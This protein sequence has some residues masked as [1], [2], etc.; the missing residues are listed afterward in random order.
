M[1]IKK[2]QIMKYLFQ[3]FFGLMAL[4][5]VSA[6]S[7]FSFQSYENDPT[8]LRLYTLDNGL[9]VYLA[10]NSDEPKIQTYIAVRAGSNYDPAD[11]TGLAHYLEHMLFKGT[12]KIGT[13]NWEIEKPYLDKISH[14]YEKHKAEPNEEKKKS[15]YKQIDSISYE[16]SKKCIANDYDKMLSS[17]GAE[18]TNAHTWYEETVYKNKVPTNELEKWLQI[19]SER[20]STLVLRLFHTELEAVY[21]EFNRAQDNDFRIVYYEL[22]RNLFPKH[23]YGQQTTI[24]ESEHLKNP[25]MV[26]I[27]DYF[28]KYYVP[29]NMAVVLVGDLDFD[30]TIALVNQYFGKWKAKEVTHPTLPN[31]DPLQETIR[32]EVSNPAAARLSLAYR[33]GG[34]HSEDRKM[35]TLIDMILSNSVAG[36]IDLNLNQQQKVL[37]AGCSTTFMNDY[38]WHSFYGNPKEG[39]SLEELESLIVG[40]V[41][42]IKRGEFD[43]WMLEAVINDLKLFEIQQFNSATGVATEMYQAFIHHQ[44]WQDVV[45]FHRSLEGIT[46]KEVVEFAKNRYQN[47]VV[48]HKK[49]GENT[50]IVK[51]ENPGITPI[52]TNRGK[53]SAFAQNIYETQPASLKPVF[54]DYQK[55]IRDERYKQLKISKIH[56]PDNDLF[57]LEYIFPLGRE[58]DPKL[59][60]AIQYL[61]YLGT[62]E[63]TPEEVKKEFY[64]LGITYGVYVANHRSY[65]YINGL[66]QNLEPGLKL[67]EKVLAKVKADDTIYNQLIDKIMKDRNNS[68]SDKQSIFWGGLY[69]KAR[70][71]KDSPNLT[72]LSQS[73]MQAI[74]PQELVSIIKGFNQYPHEVFYYG[75][76]SERVTP[77]LQ[78][79]HSI[80]AQWIEIPTRTKPALQNFDNKVYFH[81]YDMV[82]TQMGFIAKDVPFNV[83]NLAHVRVFNEYFGSG[84]SSIVFQEIR[85][86]KSLAYSAYSY[87]SVPSEK[88]DPHLLVSFVGTQANKLSQAVDAM[89]EL[90]NN[91]PK[92]IEQFESAKSAALK[93]IEAERITKDELYWQNLYNKDLGLNYDYRKQVYES[94][95]KM[96]FSDLQSFFDQHV[97]GKKFNYFVI[98]NEK[99]MDMEALARL[100]T[101]EKSE[102]K[103]LFK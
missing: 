69:N 98:G 65:V 42:K 71:G 64:K 2:T 101:L 82:Q 78:K 90:L 27:H 83:D 86:S 44:D 66:Q 24:G 32:K 28:D 54:V 10:K 92:S 60:L 102:I 89:K 5:L 46:K 20:F 1:L 19:E 7:Q 6:Q 31:E 11:N 22:M 4:S 41:D 12:H 68:E 29:N 26:A 62:E 58:H 51:V 84:L 33:F 35:V 36:L 77:L 96:K 99:D 21:E 59:T 85:E 93:K 45:D 87:Y 8:G 39:Q 103:D 13:I 67:F 52:E 100:G 14:L 70:Y 74:K 88:E 79:Y 63:M 94:I 38:G 75:K 17:L 57:Y 91:L 80:P 34:I 76:N 48:V 37:R 55:A 25:S 9:Q 97:K 61:E 56:N 50:S 53:V 16:A 40:E 43:D 47:Y 95:K 23:P 49:Q 18:G 81:N 3:L 30:K 15:I 72:R 73:E